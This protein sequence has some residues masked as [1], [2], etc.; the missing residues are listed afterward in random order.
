[1]QLL[2]VRVEIP[3]NQPIVL[4]REAEGERSLPIFIGN[5]EATAIVHAMQGIDPPRP[6]THDL[7]KR[8]LDDQRVVVRRI[9]ITDLQDRTFFA[10]VEL[11][12]DG[13]VSRIDARPSDAIALA[14]RFGADT[15]PIFADE[16]VMAEAGVVINEQD[17]EHSAEEQVEQFRSFLE[18]VSPED[19]A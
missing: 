10:E 8:V 2:G 6:M 4:L 5:P 15:V 19:F 12:R 14:V 1:M 3:S 9:D 16:S 17:P 7:L 18:Q 11:D 13:T